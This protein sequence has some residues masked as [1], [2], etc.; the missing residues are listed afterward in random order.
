MQHTC[1]HRTNRHC[2]PHAD[3]A[4]NVIDPRLPG[5]DAP[6]QCTHGKDKFSGWVGGP[7][8]S[9][10]NEKQPA[11]CKGSNLQTRAT[12]KAEIAAIPATDSLHHNFN[13][14]YRGSNRL[15]VAG[16]S[17]AAHMQAQD[18]Q[19]LHSTCRPSCQPLY[20][21]MRG[22]SQTPCKPREKIKTNKEI[23][24]TFPSCLPALNT[25][26]NITVRVKGSQPTRR[27]YRIHIRAYPENTH[28]AIILAPEPEQ[29]SKK[30]LLASQKNTPTH[31]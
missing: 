24:L 16:Q 25:A 19:A 7:V 2:I 11:Q 5:C 10:K 6:C 4:A 15:S 12:V 27:V 17:N 9:C 1:K 8:C 18:E 30:S 3:Q 13:T 26:S 20:E 31:A 28:R 23:R 21:R 22:S 29:L 14:A